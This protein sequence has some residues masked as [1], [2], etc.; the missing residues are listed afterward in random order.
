MDWADL[1]KSRAPFQVAFN[2]RERTISIGG[3]EIDARMDRVDELP[4]G[5]H[6]ILDYKATAPSVAAWFGER[7]EEPQLPMYAISNDVPVAAVAFAQVGPEGLRFKGFVADP[8]VLPGV[9]AFPE[10]SERQIEEWRRVLEP[11]AHSFREGAAAVDP[12]DG[13]ATCALCR[14]TSL[15]RIHETEPV[16]A[17]EPDATA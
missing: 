1:E 10:S 8:A 9:K 15:C 16:A 12:R 5:R 13:S 4:D 2:E 3:L 17:E 7:P 11:I 14:L 6:V